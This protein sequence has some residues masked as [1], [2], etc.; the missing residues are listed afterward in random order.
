[1]FLSQLYKDLFMIARLMGRRVSPLSDA[2]HICRHSYNSCCQTH[3][4]RQGL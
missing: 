1:M 3:Q 2:G 4:L